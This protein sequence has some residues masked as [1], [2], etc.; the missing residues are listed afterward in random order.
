LHERRVR[1]RQHAVK[2]CTAAA[3]SSARRAANPAPATQRPGGWKGCGQPIGELA[4]AENI[5]VAAEFG[6]N[7]ANSASVPSGEFTSTLR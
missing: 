1:Q 4:R 6:F 5:F 2:L 3:G 7:A